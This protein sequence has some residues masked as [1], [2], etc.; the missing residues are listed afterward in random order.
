MVKFIVEFLDLC[1][2][3]IWGITGDKP[4]TTPITQP[5][6]PQ[7]DNLDSEKGI[8]YTRLRY[9][10][11][12]KNWKEADEETYRVMIQAVGKEYGDNF[13]EDELLNFPGTDLRTIDHLWVKYSNGHFGFSVQKDIYLSVGGK[14]DGKYNLEA[15]EKF[16]DRVGWRVKKWMVSSEWI[17]YSDVN[18]NTA[19]PIGHLP[20]TVLS[21][22][23]WL[24][25]SLGR[26]WFGRLFS[27]M[28]TSKL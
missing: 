3:L 18:F 9:L 5:T 28:E 25:R 14:A 12:A 22:W 21:V 26:P 24:S 13:Y 11:A 27:R 6:A 8:D 2:K 7:T 23:P 15:W 10:L 17:S 20:L 4:G 16:G 1:R 19:F